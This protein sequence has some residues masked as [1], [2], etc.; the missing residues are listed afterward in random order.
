VDTTSTEAV[1]REHSRKPQATSW[2]GLMTS[3]VG[4]GNGFMSNELYR[5][6]AHRAEVVLVKTGNRRGRRIREADIQRALAWV[7]ANHKRFDIRIVNLSVGGDH[8]STGALTEL[9]QLVEEAVAEGLVVVAAAGNGGHE[10]VIPPASAPSALTVGGLDDQNSLDPRHRRMYASNYGRGAR[11][12]RKPDVIAPAIWLAAPM[13]PRTW[14]HNEALFLWHLER[15]SDRELARFLQSEYAETRFK[16]D[17]LRRPIDEVRRI[18]QQRMIEQKY[19]HPHYQHVDGTSMAA[20]IVSAVAAQMLEA[21]PGLSPAQVRALMRATAEPLAA[22]PKTQQGAGAVHAARVLAAALHASGGPLA[23]L[24]PSPDL[25]R[26]SVTFYYHD[27]AAREVALVGSFNDWQPHPMRRRVTGL[28]QVT[29]P[30]PR[31]GTHIY[32]FVI[33]GSYWINDPA[34]GVVAEDGYGGFH[35]VVDV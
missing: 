8:P 10:R 18:L 27:D 25:A 2:H 12:A 7:V 34:N 31:S 23:G 35:A 20:P 14:V 4:A 6:I 3:C 5:G 33:D 21:N 11:G 26:R 28:W 19:I 16:K 29:L 24:P 1:E 17:T 9:D 30:R 15:A 13:L 32:K 22:V